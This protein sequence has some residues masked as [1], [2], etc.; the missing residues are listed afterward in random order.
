MGCS[1]AVTGL[2]FSY[3]GEYLAASSN[4]EYIDIVRRFPST[5]P[6]R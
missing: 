1:H 3:D 5:E 6:P 4:G 2:S